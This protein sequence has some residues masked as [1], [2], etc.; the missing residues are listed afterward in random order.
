MRLVAAFLRFWYEFVVGDDWRLAAGAVGVLA[1]GA[2]IVSTGAAVSGLPVS[3]AIA[4]V[5][6]FALSMLAGARR[7]PR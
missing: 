1:V 3:L 2:L 5:L 7:R 6:V 4:L